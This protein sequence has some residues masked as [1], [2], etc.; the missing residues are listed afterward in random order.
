MKP[1]TLVTLGFVGALLIGVASSRAATIV[2]TS[3][4]DTLRGT[5]R[6]DRIYGKAGDDTLVGGRGNDLLVGGPGA[7]RLVCGAGKD[8]ARADAR[9]EVSPDCE[10]VRGIELPPTQPPP[11][12]PGTYC[13]ATSQGMSICLEVGSGPLGIQIVSGIRLSV[14]TTCEP[15]RE[16]TYDY[17][18]T[19]IVAIQRDRTFVSTIRIPGLRVDVEGVFDLSRASVAGSLRTQ[20][21]DARAGVEYRCDSGAL[22]WSARTPPATPTA[23]PGTYCGFTDQGF[24]LCFVVAG[25]PW[26]VSDFRTVVRT[27]CTPPASHGVSSTDP[28]S[29]AIRD[30]NTFAFS[31]TGTGTSPSGSFTVTFTMQGAFDASGSTASGTLS[32]RLTFTDASGERYECDSRPFAW[33]ARRE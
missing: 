32:A 28:T 33:T 26:T 6:A 19:T 12:S 13:G 18:L 23:R 5:P 27:E 8:V 24:G 1:A 14:Q 16:L 25:P 30:D 9:D 4:D 17:A 21:Q 15:S 3:R 7:D 11:T 29:Y 10:T 31:R 2:G 22:S 20:V